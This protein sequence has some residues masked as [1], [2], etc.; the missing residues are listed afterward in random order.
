MRV[1]RPYKTL[2]TFTALAMEADM[3]LLLLVLII[4]L[5]GFFITGF[6]VHG[7]LVLFLI[8]AA[9]CLIGAIWRGS[10]YGWRRGGR[11]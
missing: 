4:L 6:T 11:V 3:D 9:V 5:V 8:L 2:P 7:L 10:S 1:S